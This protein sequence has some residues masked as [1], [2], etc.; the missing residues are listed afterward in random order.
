MS[1]QTK[2]RQK[3]QQ[4]KQTEQELQQKKKVD[5][6]DQQSSDNPDDKD[7]GGLQGADNFRRNL[8]CGG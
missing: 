2:N 6:A 3:P 8:G 1:T 5:Q 7:F 4:K